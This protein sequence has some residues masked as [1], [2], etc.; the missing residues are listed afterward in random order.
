MAVGDCEQEVAAQSQ[1][2]FKL[3]IGLALAGLM[4]SPPAK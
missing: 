1:P 4:F 2:G 3:I